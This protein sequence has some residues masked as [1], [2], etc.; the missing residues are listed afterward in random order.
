[1]VS[2]G[3]E[4]DEEKEGMEEGEEDRDEEGKEESEESGEP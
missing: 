2:H 4:P 3:G 1:L